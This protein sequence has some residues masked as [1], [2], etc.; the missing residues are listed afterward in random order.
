MSPRKLRHESSLRLNETFTCYKCALPLFQSAILLL[1]MIAPMLDGA[2]ITEPLK[3]GSTIM[4]TGHYYT[5]KSNICDMLPGTS[6]ASEHWYLSSVRSSLGEIHESH[7]NK[8]LS[9]LFQT[10]KQN[11]DSINSKTKSKTKQ[12]TKTKRKRKKI[13]NED[14]KN[15]AS[16]NYVT[17]P[18]PLNPFDDSNPGELIHASVFSST[19]PTPDSHPDYHSWTP[20]NLDEN[21]RLLLQGNGYD[22]NERGLFFPILYRH[23][24]VQNGKWINSENLSQPPRPHS[25]NGHV[26][27]N[28]GKYT[29]VIDKLGRPWRLAQELKDLGLVRGDLPEDSSELK[30]DLYLD[31]E[32]DR[33][34]EEDEGKCEGKSERVNSAVGVPIP[35]DSVGRNGNW[36]GL[37]WIDD[38]EGDEY[39]EDDGDNDDWLLKQ[40]EQVFSSAKVLRVDAENSPITTRPHFELDD[41]RWLSHYGNLVRFKSRF[42]HTDVPKNWRE[43]GFLGRWVNYQR[44]LYGMYVKN[45]YYQYNYTVM[46]ITVPPS[47]SNDYDED[48][49]TTT[50]DVPKMAASSQ[51]LSK[52]NNFIKSSNRSSSSNTKNDN[53]AKIKVFKFDKK[54][55]P[56]SPWR[57][58]MLYDLG[59][60]FR[61]SLNWMD[62]YK[63]LSAFQKVYGHLNVPCSDNTL[64]ENQEFPGLYTWMGLQRTEYRK[65]TSKAGA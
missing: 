49:I 53:S 18:N 11:G 30:V 31:E 1:G 38:W 2:F 51:Q 13:F 4:P 32:G 17:E 50:L 6:M 61:P 46:E 62:R 19:Y 44:S 56:L 9:T 27:E 48:D 33:Y 54:I 57:I 29:S 12:K 5:Q 59:F 40:Q 10:S 23:G 20:L 43:D 41:E 64:I 15:D 58:Q 28:G 14:G 37:T 55:I 52:Q 25:F 22:T 7:W 8:Q 47:L 26:R 39:D 16:S 21:I 65:Y 24:E 60:S 34:E 42:G 45:G 3:G 36:G 35:W 63:Q